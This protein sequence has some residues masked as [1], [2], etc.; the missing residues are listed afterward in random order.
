VT[1]ARIPARTAAGA[2]GLLLLLAGCTGDPAPAP[3][4]ASAA[5]AA[6]A[7]PSP[8]S[9]G[10]SGSPDAARVRSEGSVVHAGDLTLHVWPPLDDAAVTTG[11]DGDVALA[12]PL[13][14]TDGT[15]A[16]LP[17]ATFAAGEGLTLE[18]LRDDTVVV[19]DAAGRAVGGL[20][21]PVLSGDAAGSGARV[22]VLA[23]DG[24]VTWSVLA[25]AGAVATAT[26]GTV[27]G[28][29]ATAALGSAT[30]AD[31]DD[32]GGRSL[33]VVPTSWGRAGGLAAE[34]TLWSQLVTA[35]P[36]ADAQNVHDQLTCH[37]IG[38]PDKASWNL[39]PWRPDVGLLATLGALCNPE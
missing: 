29:F 12:A 37:V 26:G 14:A 5:P 24:V 4:S 25:P 17:A 38:A 3:P 31:R 28:T 19:R 30:W 39:E 20:T 13:P 34:E 27:T 8:T 2:L 16:E 15:A 9:A 23:G 22:R 18:A 36:E 10:S 7:A 32:E 33:A 35:V 1:V 6:S 21:P 11:E